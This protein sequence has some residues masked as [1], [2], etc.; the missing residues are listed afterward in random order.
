MIN[1]EIK[2]FLCSVKSKQTNA[3]LYVPTSGTG[4]LA[5]EPGKSLSASYH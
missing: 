3:Y 5:V 2:A 4:I 1:N